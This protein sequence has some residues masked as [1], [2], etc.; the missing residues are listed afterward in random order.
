MIDHVSIAV[1]DLDRAARFY[2]PLLATLGMSKLRE[3]PDAA[4]GYG[5]K[6][7]E[8]WIN[9]RASMAP[10]ADDSGVHICLRA[11]ST[12]AVDAFHAA[13]LAAGGASDG[14]PGIRAHYYE[15][16]YAAFIRDPDGNRIEAVTFVSA[17]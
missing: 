9:K 3:W 5:K 14:A 8:F 4:I 12:D 13:A 15:S 6:Y 2:Q 10:V 1:R 7:P 17:K 16:Y 11:Q